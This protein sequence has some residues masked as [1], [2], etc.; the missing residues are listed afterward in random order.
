MCFANTLAKIYDDYCPKTCRCCDV[1]NISLKDHAEKKQ[2]AVS[3]QLSAGK[4]TGLW[5]FFP[6]ES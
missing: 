3:Y 2:S 1:Q 5:L 4:K 6:A